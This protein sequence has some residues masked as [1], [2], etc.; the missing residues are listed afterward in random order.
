M[1]RSVFRA[2][3]VSGRPG[4]VRAAV[5]VFWC[6]MLAAAPAA[7]AMAESNLVWITD[8]ETVDEDL[9]AVGQEVRIEGRVEGDLVALAGERLWIGGTVTG[10]VTALAPQVVVQ[11]QVQGSVRGVAGEVIVTG[12]VGGDVVV[13][14][15]DLQ[16]RGTVERDL[17]A[18][19][20]STVA[21]GRV[22]R[23]LRGRY[24]SLRLTGEIG[25]D[26]QV[27]GDRLRVG[28]GVAVEGDLD[29]RTDHLDGTQH[30]ES[31]VAGSVISRGELPANIRIR[32]LRVM[33][34]FMV[35]LLMVVAGLLVIRWR[36][37]WVEAASVRALRTPWRSLGMGM[38]LVLS[39]LV[40]LGLLVLVV[41]WFPF[42]IWGPVVM[43]GIPLLTIA[44]GLWMLTVLAAHIPVAVAAGRRLG[45]VFDRHWDPA[46][47]YL[48][49]TVIYLAVLQIPRL[50]VP[51]VAV[52]T[53]AGAG[54]WLGRNDRS[55]SSG[56]PSAGDTF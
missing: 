10:S 11:G 12:E 23:D 25:R 14:A 43:G 6:A 24:R 49:G 53:V 9:Y 17:L 48:V 26:V 34:V 37:P 39:P 36:T 51:L 29:Y 42:Y 50:G 27:R 45:R 18:A 33:S 41:L 4:R 21:G 20:W 47:A 44:A 7:A 35:A 13:A 3:P 31:G 16:L 8:G 30:L 1:T 40:I 19:S 56:S 46:W 28:R 54:A 22:G 52:V 2:L 38:A 15:W 5:L 32:A 55:R